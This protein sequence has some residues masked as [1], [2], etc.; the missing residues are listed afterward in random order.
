[1]KLDLET[2]KL[3]RGSHGRRSDGVC[4]M[5][6]VAWLAGEEHTDAPLCACP[7]ITRFA[8]GLNDRM[9]ERTALRTELLLPLVPRIVG[10][11]STRAVEIKRTYKL[12][13]WAVRYAAAQ[14]LRF[15]KL[16]EVAARLEGLPEVVDRQSAEAASQEAREARRH[17]AYA[18]AA[19]AASA[20]ASR[21]RLHVLRLAPALVNPCTTCTLSHSGRASARSGNPGAAGRGIRPWIPGS[22]LLPAF[23]G[24]T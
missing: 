13:D 15:A 16:P 6:A 2:L 1:V 11:R 3:E 5:E 24:M 4:V 17:A 10:T 8:Q 19:A 23:A 21:R 18:A 9:G 12:A 20:S 7:V 22:L 14:A